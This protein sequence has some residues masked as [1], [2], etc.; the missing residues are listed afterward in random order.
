MPQFEI[1]K[2]VRRHVVT[3][4]CLAFFFRLLT[5]YFV[6]GPQSVDDYSH[7][8]IPAWELLRGLPMDL[9]LWRS[10]LLVW[11]LAPFASLA[12]ILGITVSF[13]IFRV[14]LVALSLFSLWG[15]WAFG[16]Y[17]MR[18]PSFQR[19][20]DRTFLGTSSNSLAENGITDSL[21]RRLLLFPLY[22]LSLHFI[23]SFAVTRAFGESIA[24][25][26]VLVALLWMEESLD[27][28]DQWPR[29]LAG[30]LLL[31]LACLY[32]FQVGVLGIGMAAYLAG[33]KRWREFLLLAA[34]GVL[35]AIVES[36]TDLAF[37]R[38][39]LETLYNYFYVNKDGAVEHSIQPW[40]NTW[41]TMLLMLAVPFSL[42]FFRG[43]QKSIRLERLLWGLILFFTLLHGMIPH[44]E[45][46]FLYPILPL[47]LILLGR[48]WAKNFGSRYEKWFFRPVVGLLFV[49]GLAVA[50]V[51]NSQS[52]EYEPLLRAERLQVP[53]LI[54]DWDSLL[55]KSFF[56]HRLVLPPVEYVAQTAWPDAD[57]LE[58][59]RQ[60][61]QALMLVTSSPERLESLQAWLDH[62]AS[63]MQCSPIRK[64][65]SIA[66]QA[67]WALNPKYN[68]RRKPTWLVICQWGSDELEGEH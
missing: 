67:L 4:L 52:G 55:E 12:Q 44:K 34:G 13:D 37:G 33:T 61:N 5:S 7:G 48:M 14:I 51:S 42:P 56:R 68:V 2:F 19:I 36:I 60:R 38:Y 49:A 3:A 31:G 54:W 50:T 58:R 26:L 25:T 11:T 65:Q 10:P 57:L 43:I 53:V 29:F 6:Y 64:I 23:L 46:R 22:L 66:D 59:L 24:L 15:I 8:L 9:P 45:E 17:L 62:A 47:A 27:R 40:Y 21:K 30:A 16:Q 18:N 28:Q 20:D 35:A 63:P 39:P 32:R 1:Q 41:T